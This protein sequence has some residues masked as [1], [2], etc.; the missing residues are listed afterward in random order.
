MQQEMQG[1][2]VKAPCS[3]T[4]GLAYRLVSADDDRYELVHLASGLGL[5][6]AV[7]T[8][9]EAERWLALV[10]PIADWMKSAPALQADRTLSEKIQKLRRQAEEEAEALLKTLL[11]DSTAKALAQR[12]RMQHDS[13]RALVIEAAQALLEDDDDEN[14]GEGDE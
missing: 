2:N 6:G 9:W 12:A 10:A 7:E 11:P 14:D 1:T 13:F 3:G 4:P 8:R 5:G